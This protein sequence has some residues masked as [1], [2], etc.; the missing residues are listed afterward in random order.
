[1]AQKISKAEA[2]QQKI[3][4]MQKGL[5]DLG[6]A[7]Q[8]N[9]E[10]VNIDTHKNSVRNKLF[11][12][13][14]LPK[15]PDKY[16]QYN[17]DLNIILQQISDDKVS[18]A[19]N[20]YEEYKIYANSDHLNFV[21][22][23]LKLMQEGKEGYLPNYS[24]GTN[25]KYLIIDNWKSYPKDNTLSQKIY[26]RNNSSGKSYSNK[27]IP[28]KQKQNDLS[29]DKQVL[30]LESR[31]NISEEV[32][33]KNAILLKIKPVDENLKL[34]IIKKLILIYYFLNND[35]EKLN[36]DINEKEF[37]IKN[38]DKLCDEQSDELV[39][40]EDLLEHRDNIIQQFDFKKKLLQ[41]QYSMVITFMF[42]I[43]LFTLYSAVYSFDKLTNDTK[44][45][46]LDP[47]VYVLLTVF[48]NPLIRSS[49]ITYYVVLFCKYLL[50]KKEK[51]E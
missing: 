21:S 42:V 18:F 33:H 3:L 25:S 49:I 14:N 11:N 32:S 22:N 47:L 39:K 10:K 17:D 30:Q 29:T 12:E 50:C 38:L 5:F 51:K 20:N 1:M 9:Q 6:R 40:N 48:K 45:Y 16:F 4:A 24:L 44:Y 28:S 13:I 15:I 8:Q 26:I 36:K 19:C 35:I 43:N 23:K 46:V 2:E 41:F 27:Y 34:D 31:L 37:D 7:A